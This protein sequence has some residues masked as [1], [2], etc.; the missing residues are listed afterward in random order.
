LEV[1]L[2]EDSPEERQQGVRARVGVQLR[3]GFRSEPRLQRAILNF[4]H[5]GEICP[6][7]RMLT[8]SFT[9][10]GEHSLL[11]KNMEK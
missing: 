7:G 1:H 5:K 11:F 10:R 8:P 6:L 2:S 3:E 4:T 9:L